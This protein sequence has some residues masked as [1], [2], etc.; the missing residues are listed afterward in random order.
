MSEINQLWKILSGNYQKEDKLKAIEEL[1]KMAMDGSDEA[2]ET[3]YEMLNKESDPDLL[4]KPFEEPIKDSR[5]KRCRFLY[6]PRLV[7]GLPILPL[8]KI[9]STA[10]KQKIAEFAKNALHSCP[11]DRGVELSS[12][13]QI[14]K[15]TT[16]E[17]DLF[18]FVDFWLTKKDTD[19]YDLLRSIEENISLLKR[20]L[21]VLEQEPERY[22]SNFAEILKWFTKLRNPEILET[23]GKI[24]QKLPLKFKDAV[25]LYYYEESIRETKNIYEKLGEVYKEASLF[26]YRYLPFPPLPM[27]HPTLVWLE[28]FDKELVASTPFSYG[29]LEMVAAN[30]GFHIKDFIREV[31][32]QE[33]SPITLRRE[34][35]K[36]RKR[37][38]EEVF[39]EIVLIPMDK[40]LGEYLPDDHLIKLYIRDIRRAARGLIV[41]GEDLTQVVRFHMAAHAIVHL[42]RDADGRN[43]NTGAYKM[44]DGGVD[45]SPL[46]ETLAQLICYHCVLSDKDLLQCF[47]RLNKHQP[48]QYKLWERFKTL[49]LER[50]RN[51]LVGMR[52][53]RIEASFEIFESLAL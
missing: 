51:I 50:L 33:S 42:G 28:S 37:K 34:E 47:E 9:F 29:S 15:L 14:L 32:T 49:P 5:D 40:F 39:K 7:N 12:V 26:D 4:I 35:Q 45:P 48:W 8:L 22:S 1:T 20:I 19:V 18:N 36:K 31:E 25:R 46:H 30:L 2:A 44:V 3:I 52:Q 27:K 11:E 43:F 6:R 41:R 10:H 16:D 13:A 38:T 17:G 23:I 21:Q 53:G 24:W